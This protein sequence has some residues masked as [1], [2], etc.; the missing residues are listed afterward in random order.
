MTYPIQDFLNIKSA[1]F[2][3][4]SPDASKVL[5]SSNV[6]GTMQLFGTSRAGGRLTQITSFDEPVGGG[7]FPTIDDLLV[8]KD[9]G[10][11]ERTQIYRMRDD[12]TGVRNIAYDPEFIHRFGGITRDGG[13]LAYESNRRN[14]VDF[15]VYVHDLATGRE[16]LVF[17]MGGWCSASGFSPDGRLLAIGRMT[18]RSFDNDL[19]L[20]DV[21]TR[22]VHHVCPHE[23]EAVIGTPA[24]LP[25]SSG[26]Y[27]STDMERDFIAIARYDI[28]ERTWERVIERDAD[29]TVRIDWP[30]RH[31]LVTTNDEGYTR[32]DL[33]DGRTLAHVREL[34]LP[35][36]GS[37]GASFSHDGRYLGYT[38]MSAIESGDAW[39][40]D[41]ET[42]VTTRLTDVPK[43]VPRDV[44]VEPE[45]HRF[46]SFDGESVPL[47]LY[48]PRDTDGEV[49]VIVYIHGGPE[50]QYTPLFNPVIQYF[51]HRGYAVIAP[52]V[53]GS[54]GYGK[55]YHRLD[56]KRKRLDSVRDLESLYGWIAS[57]KG[58]D[59]KRAALMGGSYG[60]YMV[61]A[62]LAFQPELWAAGVDIVG[63]SSFVTFLENTAP[64]RRKFR[65]RE[66]GSLEEDY[67]FLV[68]ASPITHIDRMRAPLFIIHG[69]NDPRVPLI[70]A[71]QIH[72]ALQE[73]GVTTELLVYEDEGHG[74]AKLKNRLDAYPKAADFLDRVLRRAD[75]AP[76]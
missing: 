11:N 28:A 16:R 48:R 23:E 47:F 40:L 36:R 59:A 29:L 6:P 33:Y 50:S 71:R 75:G 14:G 42:Q 12:G 46:S 69:T 54:T 72:A 5:V 13:T 74:L 17:D 22:E 45:L 53:R 32:L 9:T 27:F 67:E 73:K 70:E 35:H 21:E 26:F 64:W 3:G 76:R 41:L 7:Y 60:G 55:R 2:A 8:L 58:L 43:P 30:G 52:N 56:D 20:V 65:E 51:V 24:W 1:S 62:G 57:A 18:E 4:F 15:D 31:V 66:Y 25:D 63:I 39:V 68:E 49:P 10:G 61:L 19:Y 37:A 38:F 34:K 44:F